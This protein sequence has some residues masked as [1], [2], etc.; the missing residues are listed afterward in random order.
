MEARRVAQGCLP[1]TVLRLGLVVFA[2]AFA[3]Y[4]LRCQ[5]DA[6]CAAGCGAPYAA[7]PD[8]IAARLPQPLALPFAL[9]SSGVTLQETRRR[10][11]RV[12]FAN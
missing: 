4:A 3:F 7:L 2:F 8:V 11:V 6:F 9:P 1:T 5:T 12:F 10:R